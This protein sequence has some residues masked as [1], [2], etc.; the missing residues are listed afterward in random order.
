MYLCDKLFKFTYWIVSFQYS[1]IVIYTPITSYSL[2]HWTLNGVHA[3]RTMLTSV[4]YDILFPWKDH[5]FLW[6]AIVYVY[7]LLCF[8]NGKIWTISHV[9]VTVTNA[10]S[11]LQWNGL[12]YQWSHDVFQQARFILPN[13]SKIVLSEVWEAICSICLR[14]GDI[15]VWGGLLIASHTPPRTPHTNSRI[16]LGPVGSFTWSVLIRYI[17]QW[18]HNEHHGVSKH[19]RL[20]C[21]LN[22]LFRHR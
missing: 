2:D 7:S 4:L 14:M 20:D 15:P 17:L 18:R 22:R 8:L 16:Y 9:Y 19:R 11:R 12:Q 6:C 21:L 13:K 5:I 10:G 1:K 3:F